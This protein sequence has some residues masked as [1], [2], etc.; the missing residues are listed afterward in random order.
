MKIPRDIKGIDLC[1]Y[2]NKY[3]Y[4]ITKQTGSHIRLTT[5]ENG[6][7]HITIPRHNPLR[8]GTANNIIK[9]VSEHLGISK[10][11]LINQLFS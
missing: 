6:E 11:D 1:K 5:Q 4:T 3:G 7:H 9:D 10:N 8:I 2:L